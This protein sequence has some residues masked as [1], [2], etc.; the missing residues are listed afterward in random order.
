AEADAEEAL[1]G[2]VVLG[3]EVGVEAVV[4][5]GEAST[6]VLGGAADPA[7]A[8]VVALGPPRLGLLQQGLLVDRVDLLEQGDVVVA[9]APHELLV[10]VAGLGVGV[11]EGGGLV[12]ELVDRDVRHAWDPLGRLFLDRTVKI[13]WPRASPPP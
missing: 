8:G 5:G 1:V 2:E 7:E 6:P 9:L 10:D 4:G 12:A 3:L 13:G 11:E